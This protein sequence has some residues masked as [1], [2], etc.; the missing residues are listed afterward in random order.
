MVKKFLAGLA[1]FAS[2][3]LS[4]AED[5]SEP[6]LYDFLVGEIAVQRG[7]LPLAA[8][9][10]L[11]LARRTRDA[12]VARRAVEIANQAKETETALAAARLWY[13]LEPSTHALQVLAATLVAAKRVDEAAPVLEKLFNA[14]GVNRENAFLQV[15]RLLAGS[16]DKTANLRVIRALAA[17]NAQMP[18]AHF[19]VAQAAAI[20]GD[21]DAALAASREAQKLRPDWELAVLLE[22]QVLQKRSPAVAAKRLGEFVE[23]Y[24]DSRD[25]RLSYARVLVQDKRLPEART[26]FEA[27]AATSPKNPEVIYA[28]GLLA[29]QV[30]DYPAAEGYM[31]R[32]LDLNYRD[33]DAVRYLLGQ[34]AEEQKLWPRAIEWYESIQDSDHMLPARMRTANAIAKQGKLDEARAFLKRVAAENPDEAVQLLVAEAQLLS[35]AQRHADAFSLLAEALDKQP[36]QPE[37]LYDLALTAEKLERFDL[38]EK[39]LRELIRIK[40][41]HAHAY[42]ALGYSFAE[43][44]MRLPEARKLIEKALEIS[45]EDYFIIDSLG[46]V[47]YREGDLKAA[48]RELRRAYVGRPDAE[49]GAHLGEVLW[50][51]GER[52]EAERIW[53]ESLK[54]SPE[55]ETL[56]KTIQRMKQRK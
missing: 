41:D 27:V 21:D 17:K 18:Q 36:Q 9:T 30:K 42:N 44:N 54:S 46:W 6:T 31:K 56:Q 26:Q 52:D 16:P 4:F 37:L 32:V 28:V 51:M 24:P 38:L 8:K 1:V 5:L 45:P 39:H 43:R 33:P 22:A 19:A 53:Q 14:E 2:C 50:V 35:D 20:A 55:N 12:R 7:D 15:N 3:N 47:L 29:F 13:E 25:A 11:A 23:K 49:I 10:Y 40:P 34:I 48:V